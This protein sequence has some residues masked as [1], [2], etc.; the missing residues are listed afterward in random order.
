VGISHFKVLL[1]QYKAK[2]T[3]EQVVKLGC[4]P[5]YT[6]TPRPT[7]ICGDAQNFNCLAATT[8]EVYFG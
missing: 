6:R 2:I 5:R 7:V 4:T 3:W 8:M 1:A